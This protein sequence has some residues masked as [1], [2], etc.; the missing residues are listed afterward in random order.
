MAITYY[1]G[2]RWTGTASDRSGLATG[3][4]IGGLA[5]L[6]TDTDDFYQW[7]GDSWNIIALRSNKT[8]YWNSSCNCSYSLLAIF[9]FWTKYA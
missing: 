2:N 6:E 3:N 5:F 1:A 9:N 8:S 7:D 4:L